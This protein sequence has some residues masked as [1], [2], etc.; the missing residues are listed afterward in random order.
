[1]LHETQ[2]IKED[3]TMV[4]ILSGISVNF[5]NCFGI[6]TNI[7]YRLSDEFPWVLCSEKPPSG[8]FKSV[9]DYVLNGRPEGL[10]TAG[11]EKILKNRSELL[12]NF[13]RGYPFKLVSGD[14]T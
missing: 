5:N 13:Q 8:E 2:F 4:K 9:N 1:M 3:G 7:Y 10:R 14:T 11:I 12:M 6:W